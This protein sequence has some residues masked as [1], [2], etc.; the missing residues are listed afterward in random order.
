MRM[1][2]EPFKIFIFLKPRARLEIQLNLL[3]TL[4]AVFF[5]FEF[6]SLLELN[7]KLLSENMVLLKNI[8]F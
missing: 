4:A 5:F 3:L 2:Y 8:K 7:Q 1:S 6:P